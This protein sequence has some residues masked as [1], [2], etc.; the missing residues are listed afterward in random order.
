MTNRQRRRED[1]QRRILQAFR[2][3]PSILGRPVSLEDVSRSLGVSRQLIHVRANELVA[4]GL[5]R[6]EKGQVRAWAVIEPP[7]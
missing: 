7:E 6:H 5:L 2:T 3:L 1:R 4:A